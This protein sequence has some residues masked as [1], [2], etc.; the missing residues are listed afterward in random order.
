MINIVPRILKLDPNWKK[1]MK[2]GDRPVSTINICLIA[3]YAVVI[4]VFFL[5]HVVF[6]IK[7]EVIKITVLFRRD[8]RNIFYFFIT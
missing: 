2:V 3:G 8:K 1:H 4:D 6:L 7:S 5:A